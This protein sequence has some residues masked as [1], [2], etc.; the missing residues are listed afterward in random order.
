MK[1][2]RTAREAP[3]FGMPEGAAEREGI[4]YAD[5][6][7][8]PFRIYGVAPGAEGEQMRRLPPQVA[9]ATSREVARL[10][11]CT[12][13]GRVRFATDSPYIA[14]F[15]RYGV[16]MAA[17]DHF[18]ATG[19]HGI[20]L[21]RD[22]ECGGSFRSAFAGAYRPGLPIRPTFSGIVNVGEGGLR[23]YTLNLPLYAPVCELWIGIREGSRLE[24]GIAY[25]NE[26]PIVYYGSSITQGGCASRPGMSYQA[27]ISAL[28]NLDYLNLGFSGS[29]RGEEAI[30]SYMA[31]L[32]P[33]V[34]VSD[35]DHNAP[36]AEHLAATC[37]AL[38]R[39][40]RAKH[41]DLPYLFVSAPL[42][43]APGGRMAQGREVILALCRRALAEGDRRVAFV[44]GAE[45][46]E[47]VCKD[48][49]TVDGTHPTDFGFF[50]MAQ[51]IGAAIDALLAGN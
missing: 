47:G 27:Q 33:L 45:I 1:N 32:D 40:V 15:C 11:L 6:R 46:F 9:E 4:V 36:T 41:P 17:M 34:F 12:A 2:D 44:D 10:S 43:F 37:E 50:R 51:K 30:V 18:A 38:Y 26:R 25:P 7:R 5:A 16:E 28:R 19:S 39:A 3:R 23:S 24:E 8:A 49:C 35:Y 21:Y 22:E 20:D 14:V 48:G 29:A 31:G 42:P 13:G